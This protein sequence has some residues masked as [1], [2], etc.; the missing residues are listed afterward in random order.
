MKTQIGR[1]GNSLA[2]RIPRI[3]AKTLGLKEGMELAEP[4]SQ[5]VPRRSLGT[6]PRGTSLVCVLFRRVRA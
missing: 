2:V 5:C 4:R 1:W 3:Y 6:R